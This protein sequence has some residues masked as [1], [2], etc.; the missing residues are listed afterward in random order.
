MEHKFK[1][2]LLLLIVT[3]ILS[4]PSIAQEELAEDDVP[5]EVLTWFYKNYDD[6]KDMKWSSVNRGDKDL[7]QV[8]FLQNNEQ[9]TSIYTLGGQILEES[10]V[11]EK[12]QLPYEIDSY[13]IS[14]FGKFKTVSLKRITSFKHV[15]DL[16]PKVH[17][18]LLYKKDGEVL[19]VWFDDEYN[20]QGKKDISNYAS[21]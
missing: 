12:P 20:V 18:E 3:G 11:N 13:A 10:S 7:L 8:E 19:S 9:I 15:G 21:N 14:K 6:P 16:K 2:V 1:L 4:Y 17:Y 5:L